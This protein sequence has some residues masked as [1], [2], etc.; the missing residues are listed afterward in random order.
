M[1]ID[2]KIIAVFSGLAGSLITVF[3]T[4][5][6]ELIQKNKEYKF[7]FRKTYFDKKLASAEKAIALW[8]SA[9]INL[10]NMAMIYDR[11]STNQNEREAEWVKELNEIYSIKFTELDKISNQIQNSV[12]LYFDLDSSGKYNYDPLKELYDRASRINRLNIS[13]SLSE[14]KFIKSKGTEYEYLTRKE[15][16]TNYQELRLCFKDLS[17]IMKD[18]Q[19]E[20]N[21]FI[22]QVRKEM[23]TY[24]M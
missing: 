21:D 24:D 9:S 7:L 13:I 11:I 2:Y 10:G 12:Y 18:A 17:T 3:I 20:L 6:I 5:I 8:Y 4:K 16:E 14:A 19:S 22:K 1:D 15:L 23:K